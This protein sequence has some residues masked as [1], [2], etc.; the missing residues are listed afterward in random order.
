MEDN[1]DI[2]RI[3]SAESKLIRDS[4][5]KDP[6][7]NKWGV[8]KSGI[9]QGVKH[10]CDYWEHYPQRIY[11]LEQRLNLPKGYFSYSIEGFYNFTEQ[12]EQIIDNAQNTGNV[13][14]VNGKLIY[15]VGKSDNPSK[16]IVVIV[17]KGKIQSIMPSDIKTF[18]KLK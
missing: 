2:P 17:Y 6:L 3:D 18:H 1:G 13:R 14:E 10:F 15:Y 7:A 5:S 4:I 12:I 11:S 9:N 8:S 16:G